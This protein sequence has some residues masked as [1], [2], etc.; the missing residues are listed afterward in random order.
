VYY[1]SP[2]GKMMAVS[3]AINGSTPVLGTP[4][5]LFDAGLINGGASILGLRQQYDVSKDGRFLLNVLAE[6]GSMPPITV[7]LNWAPPRGH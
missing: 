5:A 2:D 7:L 3:V 4:V 6:G 1:I